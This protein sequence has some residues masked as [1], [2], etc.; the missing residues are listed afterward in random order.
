MQYLY[1]KETKS[2]FAIERETPDQKRLEAFVGLLKG[3]GHTPLT[4]DSLVT[5]QNSVVDERYR[6]QTWRTDQVYVGE[7]ITPGYEKVQKE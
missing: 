5:A 1:V 2:S 7:T 4:K 6:Q 3:L